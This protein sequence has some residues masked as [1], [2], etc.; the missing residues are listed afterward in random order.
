MGRAV[1]NIEVS[2]I[3]V[4]EGKYGGDESVFRERSIEEAD[5]ADVEAGLLRWSKG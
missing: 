2:G 3:R 4:E 1:P 5:L